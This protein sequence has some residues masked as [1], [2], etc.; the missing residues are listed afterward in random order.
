MGIAKCYISKYVGRAKV[1]V[2]AF[3]CVGLGGLWRWPAGRWEMIIWVYIALDIARQSLRSI[4][5]G[6]NQSLHFRE[7]RHHDSREEAGLPM[8][9][10]L[11][12]K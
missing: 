1:R 9:S 11:F 12:T 7:W 10:G 2:A 8:Y 5:H 3:A 4:L 6:V